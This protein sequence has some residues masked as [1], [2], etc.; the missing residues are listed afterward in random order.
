MN[1]LDRALQRQVGGTH[2][3]NMKIQPMEYLLVNNISYIEGNIIKY[4]S[5]WRTREGLQDLEKA[6]HYLELLIAH[7]KAK[8]E[9]MSQYKNKPKLWSMKSAEA[10]EEPNQPGTPADG[11]HHAKQSDE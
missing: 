1:D 3:K 5:C 4:V 2:Y 8:Q 7:E 6:Q 9:N 10:D 11:G